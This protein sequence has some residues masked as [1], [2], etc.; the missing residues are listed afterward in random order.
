M[1]TFLVKI[2]AMVCILT[3]GLMT[4]TPFTP[5]LAHSTFDEM[6]AKQVT[7]VYPDGS[8]RYF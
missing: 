5:E 4:W 2:I 8:K 3:V 6:G 7:Y 1:K